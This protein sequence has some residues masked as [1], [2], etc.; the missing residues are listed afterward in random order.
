[1]N[2]TLKKIL[3]HG[4]ALA[5]LLIISIVYFHPALSGYSLKTHDIKMHKGMSKEVFDFRQEFNKEPLWTNSM[6]GGMP[7]TQISV[8][9]SSNWMDYVYDVIT[10]KLPR[11]IS[12]LW[13]YFLGFYILLMCLKI[14]PWIGVLG[15]IAFGFSTYFI[16]IL[17]AGHMSKANAISFMAPSIGGIWLLMRGDY[18]KGTVLTALFLSLE[19][20]CNHIQITYYMFFIVA[21][22]ILG[23]TVRLVMQKNFKGIAISGGLIAAGIGIAVMVNLPLLWGTYE[24]GKYTTR[25]KSE[26]TIPSPGSD[27]ADRTDGLDRSYV[28]QWSYGKG[29]T[30]T[31]FVPNAK[32]GGSGSLGE[33][34]YENDIEPNENLQLLLQNVGANTYWGNQPGTSGPVYLGAIV[35]LLALLSLYYVRQWTTY[36]LLAVTIITVML[37]W[38]SNLMWLT[39]FF[40]DYFPGYNK[41]RAVTMILVV[42]ELCVPLMG[43]LFL[44]QLYTKREAIK[45]DL[46]GLYAIGGFVVGLSLLML[47][48][49]KT[50]F[51][52]QSDYEKEA[53]SIAAIEDN[54]E[55]STQQKA[56]MINFFEETLPALENMRISIFRKDL[57]R[58]LGLVLIAG[59]LILLFIHQKTNATVLFSGL[60]ILIMVDMMGVAQRLLNND[61]DGGDYISWVENAQEQNPYSAYKG[62]YDI[63]LLEKQENQAIEQAISAKL[64]EAKQNSED[65]LSKAQQQAIEFGVLNKLTNF[66]VFCVSNPFNEARTSYFH[67]SIGGYHGAK[68]KRYQ[69]LI[70][71]HVGQNNS[72]VLDMLN[73]KYLMQLTDPNT[74]KESSVIQPNPN[75]LG[76][77]WIVDDLRYVNNAD[78]EILALGKEE[79]F[80]P[81]NT[82]IVD[83]RYKNQAGEPARRVA[84]AQI[85]LTSYLP[86]EL[87]YSFTA[88]TEQIVIFSEI[89]YELGWQAYIDDQPVDHFRANYVLR[90]LRVPAGQHTIVFKY[91]LQSFNTGS[92][93]ATF[94]S[95]LVIVGIGILL[96]AAI[97]KPEWLSVNSEATPQ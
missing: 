14:D 83:I 21:A 38:G 36:A 55:M 3:P 75:A 30:F 48:T 61:K 93:I 45:Q 19:L 68:L 73:T 79:G 43:V 56:G 31:F 32:G 20:W 24:Y 35:L 2:P 1:M 84:D 70:E 74:S 42:A 60:I 7:A 64:S 78:E 49:P 46:K 67:K 89:Y 12:I 47:A 69:E 58:S 34:L 23:E 72:A 77:A 65:G 87:T 22:I 27:S 28:T 4:I 81:A 95:L 6:F 91:E 8:V 18:L 9:Y 59:M 44:H 82:A 37:S 50:F 40:L 76:N 57:G 10:L 94:G 90:G 63:L 53:F 97:K 52:F 29:E 16:V 71:F 41:F 80:D 26:L 86:N 51:D 33:Y 39:D 11:P 17:E 25:G 92:V 54:M 5:V 62:D 88:S 96:F 66:R 85:N 15:A 13:M